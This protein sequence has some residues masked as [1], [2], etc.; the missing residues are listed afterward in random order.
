MQIAGGYVG[1]SMGAGTSARVASAPVRAD[2]LRVGDVVRV[3]SREEILATLDDEGRVDG[4]P[5]M[6]E[7]LA[8]AGR[9]V[10]VDAVTHR[11]CD[12]VKTSGTSGTTRRLKGAVHLT[13]L[14]CDGSAHGGCQA[15]CLLYWKED[16]LE[17]APRDSRSWS[18]N[19]DPLSVGDVPAA[20]WT[21]THGVGH[22]DE[23]PVY[24]CQATEL[25]RAT[26]FVSA[27]APTMWVKDV[28]SRNAGVA[29]ALASLT[30]LFF[31]KWQS[32]STHLPRWLRIQQGRSWPWFTPTGER[33]SY[34]TLDLQPGEPVEV[35]SQREIEATL[36]D[37]GELRGLRF[38]AEM[39]PYCGR[40]ARVLARVDRIIDE[41]TGRMLKLR[42][43]II[44]E[45]GWCHGTFRALCRR[46]IYTYWREAWLRRVDTDARELHDV[47]Q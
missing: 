29:S 43:C 45:D 16:W 10:P 26:Q 7:M 2:A 32:A 37:K 15:R 23:I 17:P 34:P 19:G 46:K 1:G 20:L 22:T 12:T 44:L 21:A 31:N 28:R 30:V 27:R 36:N 38:S 11:T 35:K 39:L 4:L 47:A 9:V 40:Q 13:G 3:K 25:L 42:D 33:R 18:G 14:R 24:S 6:P 5:F 41:K 8:F